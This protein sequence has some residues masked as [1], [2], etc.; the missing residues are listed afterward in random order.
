MLNR[1]SHGGSSPRLSLFTLLI[2]IYLLVYT[3]RINAIDETSILSVA[4]S[5]AR[6]GTLD[7]EANGTAN[8]MLSLDFSRVDT[9]ADNGTLYSKK[10]VLSSLG[11]TPLVWVADRF[12]WLDARAAVLLFT[13]LV[14]AATAAAVFTLAVRTGSPPWAAWSA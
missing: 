6:Q 1:H 3:G 13:P 14:T 4:A 10:G 5:L 9:T 2:G 8:W 7:S 11:M 12:P